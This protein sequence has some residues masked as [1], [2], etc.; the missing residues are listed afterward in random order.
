MERLKRTEVLEWNVTLSEI[1]KKS[2]DELNQI[3]ETI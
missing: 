2:I 1:L 3:F